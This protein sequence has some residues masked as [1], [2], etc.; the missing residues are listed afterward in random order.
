NKDGSYAGEVTPTRFQFTSDKLVY[1]LKITQISVKDKTEALFYVQAPYKV[2]LP[3]DMT[4]QYTWVPMLKSSAKKPA[5]ANL[6]G[7]GSEWLVAIDG[8]IPNLM[9]RANGLGFTFVQGQRPR[10]NAKGHIPT[11]MEWARKLT[12]DDIKVLQGKAPYS[13]VIP[14]VDEGF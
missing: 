9:D 4:Y 14:N 13:E 5:Y 1:P 2:D 8:L 12:E 3:G 10:P 7:R 11:T 6:P